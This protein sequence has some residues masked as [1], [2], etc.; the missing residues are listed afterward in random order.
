MASQTTTAVF[1]RGG[2][3]GGAAACACW[4]APELVLATTSIVSSAAV[5]PQAR[6][7]WL[8]ARVVFNRSPHAFCRLSWQKTKPAC[9]QLYVGG[10]YALG[11][12]LVT[13]MGRRPF[14][15]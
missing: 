8:L 1:Q 13:R 4:G 5:R 6:F 15:S 12:S 2:M 11:A 9:A 7:R 3:A 10:F 14:A